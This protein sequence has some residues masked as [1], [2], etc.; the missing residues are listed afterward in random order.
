MRLQNDDGETAFK[1]ILIVDDEKFIL[2]IFSQFLGEKG[3]DIQTAT[4]SSCAKEYLKSNCFD[5]I[6]S[7]VHMKNSEFSDFLDFLKSPLSNHESIPIIAVTG[8]PHA[9]GVNEKLLLSYVLEK[10]FTPDEL[11]VCINQFI[12]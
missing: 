6:L 9:I 12:N 5:L 11:L 4:S 2:D 7:D 10:P 1:N 3:F 8:V